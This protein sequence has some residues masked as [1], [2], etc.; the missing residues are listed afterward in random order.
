MQLT[1]REEIDPM[2]PIYR[3]VHICEEGF[4]HYFKQMFR[5]DASSFGTNSK[6]KLFGNQYLYPQSL[7]IHDED[8]NEKYEKF[9]GI[10]SLPRAYT[11]LKMFYLSMLEPVARNSSTFIKDNR[12]SV[13]SY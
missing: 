6:G 4:V 9:F 8:A 11:L 5:Q 10:Y 7:T 1:R 13:A 2:L 12:L 3:G